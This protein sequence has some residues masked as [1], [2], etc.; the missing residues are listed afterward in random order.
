MAVGEVGSA[1]TSSNSYELTMGMICLRR[2]GQS[3]A[4]VWEASAGWEEAKQEPG[5]RACQGLALP[6]PSL[7]CPQLTR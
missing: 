2:S 7:P 5:L 1:G 3:P 4:V 6:A